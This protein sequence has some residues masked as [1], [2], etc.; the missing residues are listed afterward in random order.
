M[1]NTP[2][3][4]RTLVIVALTLIAGTTLADG[5]RHGGMRGPDVDRLA[6]VLDLDDQQKQEVEQIMTAHRAAAEAR[7]EAHRASGERPD[8]ETIEA[9][10]EQMRASL[11][12]QLANVLSVEQLEKFDAMRAMRGDQRPRHHKRRDC[13]RYNEEAG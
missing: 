6:I 3:T 12:S 2:M 8:R 9:T 5:P 13:D 11:H 1:E 7:R 10:R 4:Y